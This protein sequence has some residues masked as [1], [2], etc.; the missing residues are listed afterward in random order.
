MMLGNCARQNA[1]HPVGASV[2]YR[3]SPKPHK[4]GESRLFAPF[5]KGDGN[6]ALLKRRKFGGFSIVAG[7]GLVI[8]HDTWVFVALAPE[9]GWIQLT[10]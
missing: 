5:S 2:R 7:H 4:I 8:R 1:R 6:I 9:L 10:R 3:K